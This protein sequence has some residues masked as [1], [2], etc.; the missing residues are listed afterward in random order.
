VAV[1][2]SQPEQS[3]TTTTS[4]PLVIKIGAL[5]PLSG[6]LADEGQSA[7]KGMRLA[8]AE[9]NQDGGIKA[10]GG[11]LLTLAEADSK[12]DADGA[13]AEV[14][15]LVKTEGVA[16]VVGTG[17]STV[18]LE[19]TAAAEDL[20]TPFIVSSGAADEITGRGLAYTFRLCPK[21]DWYAR[22][23]VAFL[24]A[25]QNLVGL[26]I[27]KVALLHED[28]EFGKQ[29]AASQK[30]YLADAGIQVVTDIEYSPALADF[31]NQVLTIKQSGA[32]AILTATLLNDAA[33]IAQA[34]A[35]LHANVPIV[36]AA[37]GVLDSGFIANAG[38]SAEQMMSVSEFAAGMAPSK[39]LEQKVTDS[40]A[41][42]DADL[43][44]GYQAVWLLAD[45]LQRAGSTD[46]PGFRAALASTVLS[47]EH[48]VLPQGL[49]TF[50]DTGQNRAARLLVLQVQDG[51]MVPVWPK[52]Y[53]QGT[54]LLAA[55]LQ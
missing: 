42:L 38:A 15:R 30:R 31:S 3:G 14:D 23:Q 26:D 46:E 22:D 27:T 52:E 6:D 34:A 18:A 8:I 12:G 39:T 37:G 17:Q 20:Q 29:T 25:L 7:L 2:T 9:V 33:L 44:Y 50:D 45:A 36:D 19:A 11:A 53:A 40:G 55:P 13:K 10:L 41:V 47:G 48:L 35:V 49:L 28:G 43:L 51:R 54:V 1:S 21:A 24:A 32:Q 16:A 5:F 4:G